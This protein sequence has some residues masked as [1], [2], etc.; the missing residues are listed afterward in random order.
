MKRQ[1]SGASNGGQFAPD[2][3]GKKPP[4]SLADVPRDIGQTPATVAHDDTLRHYAA[5]AS[6]QTSQTDWAPPTNLHEHATVLAGEMDGD[7]F[8]DEEPR[9]NGAYRERFY[10]ELARRVLPDMKDASAD[11]IR[12]MGIRIDRAGNSLYHMWLASALRKEVAYRNNGLDSSEEVS[13]IEDAN[14]RVAED[15]RHQG[16]A[17]DPASLMEVRLSEVQMGLAD[18]T[19][20]SI[21]V[22]PPSGYEIEVSKSDARALLLSRGIQPAKVRPYEPIWPVSAS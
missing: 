13:P 18:S 21:T 6:A 11:E 14:T 12:E 5:F 17:Y 2:M 9:E 10:R 7:P 20:E 22:K 19:R 16:A 15:L 4:A 8:L 1:P 3:R